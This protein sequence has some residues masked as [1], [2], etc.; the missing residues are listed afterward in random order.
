MSLA[1]GS[2]QYVLSGCCVCFSCF[3]A[4]FNSFPLILEEIT[5]NKSDAFV[6]SLSVSFRHG[7]FDLQL[8]DA[9]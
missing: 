7:R 8:R 1:Y 6:T 5:L 2:G 3:P 9:V 4:C